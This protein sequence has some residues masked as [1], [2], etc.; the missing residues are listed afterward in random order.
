MR[1]RESGHDADRIVRHFVFVA[2]VDHIE[3]PP[4]LLVDVCVFH[5]HPVAV[6]RT[7]RPESVGDLW[8]PDA[9]SVFQL[10]ADLQPMISL[11]L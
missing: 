2:P 11:A 3:V 10:L 5:T 9:V 8:G 7:A 6:L 1:G 4:P